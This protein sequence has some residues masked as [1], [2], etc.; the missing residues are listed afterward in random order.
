M[1]TGR[2]T[3]RVGV[4][5]HFD[6]LQVG[7][8]LLETADQL[9]NRFTAL[10]GDV[11]IA[12]FAEGKQ[13]V[14]GQGVIRERGRCHRQIVTGLH[15]RGAGQCLNLLAHAR[16]LAFGFYPRDRLRGAMTVFANP[17]E[18]GLAAVQAGREHIGGFAF[19]LRGIFQIGAQA[20]IARCHA[21]R[22]VTTGQQTGMKLAVDIHMG[23]AL[24]G[25]HGIG[26]VI[27]HL[28]LT[29]GN[30]CHRGI[31]SAEDF[32]RDSARLEFLGRGK[33]GTGQGHAQ[34]CNVKDGYTFKHN[35]DSTA[36]TPRRPQL[37]NWIEAG[38]TNRM[39]S[40]ALHRQGLRRVFAFTPGWW[41]PRPE[42]A[43]EHRDSS[44][45]RRCTSHPRP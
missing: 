3:D 17:Q 23:S 1:V 12:R 10:E 37:M 13:Y 21:K 41:S 8:F 19:V 5:D 24:L 42:P 18:V 35:H 22:A 27:H 39:A 28:H 6:A 4:T 45:G 33:L 32:V 16:Q 2:R 25:A 29:I 36:N 15:G 40:S 11:L 20:V 44:A 31:L 38:R 43:T 30:R 26:A 34:Q 9:A 14:T 7:V